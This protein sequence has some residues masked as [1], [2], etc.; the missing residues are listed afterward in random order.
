MSRWSVDIPGQ[1]PTTNNQ[2]VLRDRRGGLKVRGWSD[3]YYAYRDKVAQLVQQ[4]KPRRLVLPDYRPRLGQGQL[5][6]EID[7]ELTRDMDCDNMLKPLLDGIKIGLGT[8]PKR[9]RTGTMWIAPIYDDAGFLPRFM[10]KR[11]VRD[12]PR[13]IL[14]LSEAG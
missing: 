10:S 3:D 11:V 8:E 7:L 5:V 9:S 13:V 6:I 12:E 4:A 2:H 14:T 1:P